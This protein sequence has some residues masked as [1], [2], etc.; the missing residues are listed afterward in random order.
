MDM[1]T[2]IMI[3]RLVLVVVMLSG[4]IHIEAYE[5]DT[6]NGYDYMD[7]PVL[8]LTLLLAIRLVMV[9]SQRSLSGYTVL[10]SALAAGTPLI[11]LAGSFRI[12]YSVMKNR[13]MGAVP[14]LFF[15]I[16]GLNQRPP[17]SKNWAV[18]VAACAVI[19]LVS[20][21]G[22]WLAQRQTPAGSGGKTS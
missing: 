10:V 17:A 22:Q 8:I 13:S 21:I 7:L 15:T 20:D 9:L 19:L 16:T 11:K 14:K 5:L 2:L 1:A 12:F 3:T 18:A 6:T 4:I